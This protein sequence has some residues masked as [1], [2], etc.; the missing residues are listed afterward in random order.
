[1]KAGSFEFVPLE[2][3]RLSPDLRYR[4]EFPKLE[5]LMRS[6]MGSNKQ[7]LPIIVNTKGELV[8]GR[9]RLEAAKKLGWDK[10]LCRIVDLPEPEVA[11]RDE[12]DEREPVTFREKLALAK[13]IEAVE[14]LKAS[15]REKAGRPSSKL[16]EGRTD[17]KSAESVGWS[18]DT[19]RAAKTV[20]E[21]GTEALNDAVQAGDV[22]IH[23]AAKVA[24]QPPEVQDEAVGAVQNGQARTASEAAGVTP[25]RPPPARPKRKR[26]ANGKPLFSLDAF[27]EHVGRAIGE[28]D[29]L[30]RQY[31]QVEQAGGKKVQWE[32]VH[33]EKHEAIRKTLQGAIEEARQWQR[34]LKKAAK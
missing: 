27:T 17:S 3:V 14:K 20:D 6:M 8:V 25:T 2:N 12:N 5:T 32:R 23:D 7:L 26:S 15:K 4:E 13:A 16:D 33:S 22:S 18:K 10:I 9:R 30:A 24:T 19:F 21:K 28:L 11:Q 34:E 31:G 1:M 29:K